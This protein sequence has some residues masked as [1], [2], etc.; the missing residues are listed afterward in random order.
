MGMS[1]DN[2]FQNYHL[3]DIFLD[4]QQDVLIIQIILL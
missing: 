4:N 2:A 3:F 1:V